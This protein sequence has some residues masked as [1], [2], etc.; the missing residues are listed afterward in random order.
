M[1]DNFRNIWGVSLS[2]L[3]FSFAA[4]TASAQ[5]CDTPP[6][7]EELGYT[8]TEAQCVGLK[9]L[10]CPFDK[11]KISCGTSLS[12]DE[13]LAQNIPLQDGDIVYKDGTWSRP[14]TALPDKQAIGIVVNAST[15]LVLLEG[16]GTPESYNSTFCQYKCASIAHAINTA[17]NYLCT[18]HLPSL[19]EAQLLKDKYSMIANLKTATSTS[20]IVKNLNLISISS[21]GYTFGGGTQS[22]SIWLKGGTPYNM[23]N[24]YQMTAVSQM[25]FPHICV[26]ILP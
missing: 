19:E 16:N 18:G 13:F 10:K 2:I 11:S 20:P 23:V 8:M 4:S 7:C 14:T 9:T 17:P 1:T 21:D 22:A 12:R 15:K 3:A 24:N 26:G 5:T 6:S 25:K